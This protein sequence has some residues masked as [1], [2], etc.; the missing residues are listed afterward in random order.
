LTNQVSKKLRLK[1]MASRFEN[2]E[3][4]NIDIIGAYLFGERDFD[5]RNPTYG[6]IVNPLGAGIYQNWAR[7]ELNITNWNFSHKGNAD[8]GKNAVQWGLGFDRTGISDKLN[9]W[10]FQDSAGYALPYQPD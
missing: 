8:L 1:W 5:K 3:S 10:E 2:D 7:N 6:M 9:E 4:E